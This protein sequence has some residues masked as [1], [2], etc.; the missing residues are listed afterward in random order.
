MLDCGLLDVHLRPFFA[1]ICSFS[2]QF[3]S[4]SENRPQNLQLNWNSKSAAELTIPEEVSYLWLSPFRYNVAIFVWLSQSF[5]CLQYAEF[6]SIWKLQSVEFPRETDLA[7]QWFPEMPHFKVLFL[8]G[9]RRIILPE[10]L[11][12]PSILLRELD[13]VVA[14]I[15]MWREQRPRVW[16]PWFPNRGWRLPAEHRLRWVKKEVK[17]K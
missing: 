16:N 10:G 4:G 12:Y 17:L 14:T 1:L 11:S 7:Q 6:C 2:S 13:I 3:P 8:W 5:T 9:Q 15:V